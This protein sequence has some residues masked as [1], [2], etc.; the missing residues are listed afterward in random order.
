MH[1]GSVV[2]SVCTV[3]ESCLILYLQNL[4]ETVRIFRSFRE[5]SQR[6][7]QMPNTALHI[8]ETTLH[9]LIVPASRCQTPGSQFTLSDFHLRRTKKLDIICLSICI[10]CKSGSHIHLKAQWPDLHSFVEIFVLL[11]RKLASQWT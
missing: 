9:S 4:A 7:S 3:D 11:I 6:S 8:F 5:V 10:Y 2:S 1:F